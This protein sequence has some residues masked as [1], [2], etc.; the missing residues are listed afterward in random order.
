MSSLL[1]LQHKFQS[2]LMYSDPDFKSSINNTGKLS[3]ETRLSIYQNAYR[4]RLIDALAANYPVLYKYLGC[5]QFNELAES[6]L[7][8]YPSLYRSIRWFGDK[9]A[10]FLYQN[11]PYSNI[12]YLSELAQFEWT[13]TSVFDASDEPVLKIEDI[14]NIQPEKWPC[15]RF[16][17][18]ASLYRVNLVWNVVQIWQAI[19]QDQLPPEPIEYSAPTLWVLWRKELM[20]QFCSIPEDEAWAIGAMLQRYHFSEICEGLC[21]WVEEDEAG[22]R[23]ASLLKGWIQSGLLTGIIVE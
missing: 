15:M 18:H 10:L 12:P 2:C 7:K 14:V 3:V 9:L 22:L 23:A 11:A 16:R 20:N 6:Y 1:D 17:P 5:D 4:I 19:M 21:R 13:M 8:Y